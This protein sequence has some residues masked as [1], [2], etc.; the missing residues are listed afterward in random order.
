MYHRGIRFSGDG[1]AI[2]S[3]ILIEAPCSS[4]REKHWPSD[5][6]SGPY[7]DTD[8]E[9]KRA[10]HRL[11]RAM[12]IKCPCYEQSYIII[13]DGHIGIPHNEHCPETHW[14]KKESV[15]H[16]HPDDILFIEPDQKPLSVKSLFD[17]VRELRQ[18]VE[19][20]RG[21]LCDSQEQTKS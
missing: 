9:C 13:S 6:K 11:F 19:Q 16:V 21:K 7:F 2:Q 20:L 3:T 10:D 4:A 12:K 14:K 8:A 15:I 1:H 5:C 18:T 17:E